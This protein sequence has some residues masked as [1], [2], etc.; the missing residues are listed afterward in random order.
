MGREA[1]RTG[2]RP[3]LESCSWAQTTITCPY[4]LLSAEPATSWQHEWGVLLEAD[5]LT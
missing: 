1:L 3:L 5:Q 2:E 4:S